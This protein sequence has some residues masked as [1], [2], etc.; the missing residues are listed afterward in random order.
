MRRALLL[1]ALAAAAS[2]G[3]AIVEDKPVEAARRAPRGTAGR[4]YRFR[5][6]ASAAPLEIRRDLALKEIAGL[7]GAARRG[8]KT[9]G[10]TIIKHELATHT[11]FKTSIGDTAVSAWFD[12]VILDVRVASTVI[13]VPRE[14]PPG[15]CEHDAVLAHERGHGRYARVHAAQLA[16]DLEDAL[17]RAEGLPTRSSPMIATDYASVAEELKRALSRVVD[18]IYARFEKEEAEGQARLDRPDPYDAVYRRC[19]NWK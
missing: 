7:P 5:V 19:S 12:D 6:S 3:P 18:P 17:S 8:L 1:A 2:C 9:Q 15:T 13:H 16:R 14:Y 11:S 4:F 10:I